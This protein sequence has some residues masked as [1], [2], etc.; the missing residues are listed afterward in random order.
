MAARQRLNEEQARLW[1]GTTGQDWV[2]L[3]P[4]LD[5]TFKPFEDLL[6]AAVAGLAS[7]VRG[8]V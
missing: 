3:Q 2:E 5:E 1:N 7:I 6:V 4:L 8:F